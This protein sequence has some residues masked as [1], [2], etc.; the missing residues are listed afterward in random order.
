MARKVEA[1]ERGELT[2]LIISMPPRHGK[3]MTVTETLPSWFIGKN[4]DRRVIEVSY[5]DDLARDFGEK[6]RKKVAEFGQEVFGI[7]LERGKTDK[8]DWGIAGHAGGMVSTGIGGA[9][10]GK[11]ADLLIIDDP[12]KNRTEADSE[13]YRNR[14]WSEW[15]STLSTRLHPGGRVVVIMTRWHEDDLV[16]R[17]LESEPGRWEV[18]NLPAMA[19]ADDPM[20]RTEGEALWPGRYSRGDLEMIKV[21]VGSREWQ[22]LYQGRPS[23]QAG[24][25]FKRAFWQEYSLPPQEMARNMETVI[26]SWDCTFKDSKG[27]DYVAG[28]VWGRK[29]ADYYLLDLVHD[30]MDF[31]ATIKAIRSMSAKWPQARGKLVE[32]KANGPAVIAT[33]KHEISGLIAVEPEGGKI[34][35]AN[36]IASYHEAGNLWLPKPQFA[37]WVHDFIE[38]AAAFPNGKYDDRVDEMTQAVIW[39]SRRGGSM[40]SVGGPRAAM[41]LGIR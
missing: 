11:G 27:T 7:E 17:L 10:S 15:Q 32:D 21:T 16:S 12:I 36:A 5:G 38:E 8:T 26:Q 24:S 25:I 1:V 23:P 28:G 4:P 22:A 18:L 20:G 34:V 41:K 39:L 2:R 13:V 9:I 35:R 19:E 29:G 6:N 37:P 31:P 3:S 14:V 40:V 30:R 33:L